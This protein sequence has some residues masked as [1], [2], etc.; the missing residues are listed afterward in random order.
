MIPYERIL[1]GF[2]NVMLIDDRVSRLESAQSKL[3]ASVEKKLQDHEKRLIRMETIIEIV[4][5]GGDATLRIAPPPPETD[6]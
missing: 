6:S 5:P 2:K 4:R 3:S 1:A